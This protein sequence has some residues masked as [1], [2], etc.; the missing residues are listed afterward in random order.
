MTR[1]GSTTG[2]THLRMTKAEAA[3]VIIAGR[4]YEV[5]RKCFPYNYGHPGRSVC[6]QC[7]G[8]GT[9]HSMRY[10]HACRVLGIDKAEWPIRVFRGSDKA[11]WARLTRRLKI[12]D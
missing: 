8:Q 11:W 4:K 6:F 7:H 2:S 3:E 12:H 5:C 1:T 9:K 10:L